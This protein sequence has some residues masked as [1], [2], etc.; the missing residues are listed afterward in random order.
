MLQL[1]PALELSIEPLAKDGRGFRLTAGGTVGALEI[2]DLS[3][4]IE[5][6]IGIPQ[7]LAIACYAVGLLKPQE[8]RPFD[9][10]ERRSL[11]DALALALAAA[12]RRAFS[13][14][15]LHGY[16]T[17]EQALQTVRGQ[18]RL[19]EQLRRR[20]AAG[21]PVEVR[22]DD[23]TDDILENQLVRAAVGRL[24]A[25]RLRSRQARRE[26][27]WVAA[28]LE[29]VSAVEFGPRDV[30]DIRFD[31][32]NEHYRAVVGLA[33]LVL[34]HGAFESGRGSIRAS[35]FLIDMNRLFQE[36]LTVALRE[37]LGGSERTFPGDRDIPEIWLAEGERLRLKPD[38]SWWNGR[39]CTF[40]GDAKYKKLNDSSAP[41]A[42]LY[43]LLAYATALDLP[44]GLLV[45]AEGEAEPASFQVRHADRR[46]EVMALDLSGTLEAV[47]GRVDRVA[48]Q[49]R[50]LRDEALRERRA[51]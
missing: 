39:S 46:L 36:F 25:M 28:T 49:V 40:V 19:T 48:E 16:R 4:R 32:L 33:R 7:L 3:I 14:G 26:L 43:Q 11:P 29:Q 35:G 15:L 31:R 9:F 37:A 21:L 47:L 51:A 17:E 13:Q 1:A 18:I 8:Q 38:L 30:P 5:P 50:R 23:F 45:Y 2:G 41:T 44:G 20:F 22:F 34:R 12:A 42:D 6:K 24:G 10:E 27:G